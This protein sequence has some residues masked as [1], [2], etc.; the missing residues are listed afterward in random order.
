[1]NLP[2]KLHVYWPVF[3]HIKDYFCLKTGLLIA[4]VFMGNQL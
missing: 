4:S 1:M 2:E 3:I